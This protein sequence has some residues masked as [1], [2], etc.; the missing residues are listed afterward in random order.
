[1]LSC[2][3]V[4]VRVFMC[5]VCLCACTGAACCRHH[6]IDSYG[7]EDQPREE[8]WPTATE[9]IDSVM[10]PVSKELS[11][12]LA[13]KLGARRGMNTRLD[14]CG[15]GDGVVIADTGPLRMLCDKNPDVKFLATFLSRVNQHEVGW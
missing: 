2:A 9:L 15:G 13:M 1:M 10:V 3:W 5:D 14:C 6:Q 4:R 11:L 12:P 8:G 7:P